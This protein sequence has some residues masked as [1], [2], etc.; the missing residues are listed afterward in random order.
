MEQERPSAQN[1]TLKLKLDPVSPKDA[2]PDSSGVIALTTA[3][4]STA[5]YT[6]APTLVAAAQPTPL[7]GPLLLLAGA[8]GL[9]LNLMPCVFPILAMKAMALTRLSGAETRRVRSEAASYCAGVIL[10]FVALGAGLAALREAGQVAGWGFQFQS[11]IFVIAIAWLLFAIG[12]SLSG[13]FSVGTS[14]MG[15]GHA[16]TSK[17]GHLGSALT[18]ALAVVVATPCTAPFMGTAIAGALALPTAAGLAVFGA[19]GAGLALPYALIALIPRLTRVL[20]RPGLWMVTLQQLLAFPMYAA[21]VW[22]IWVVSQQAGPAGVVTAGS[23][24]VAV[25]FAAWAW[26]FAA[27]RHGWSGLLAASLRLWRRRLS[28]RYSVCRRGGSG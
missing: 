24:L 21:A 17:G 20:P 16:L 23:G 25:G 13:V 27:R 1:G 8:G 9:L 22:L 3:S 14:L 2:P 12:L 11:P 26:G 15:R 7:I 28:S 4:G 5:A 10:A 6:I 19:L 18:G